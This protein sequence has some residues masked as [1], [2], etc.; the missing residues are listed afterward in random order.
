MASSPQTVI[1]M[2][3]PRANAATAPQTTPNKVVGA[4]ADN[5]VPVMAATAGSG[6]TMADKVMTS[7]A[8]LAQLLPTGT[9]L[10]YQ[11][12]SPSFTR[13]GVDCTASNQWLTAA[14]VG[15]LAGLSLLLSF[16]DSVVGTDGRLY[17]GVATPRGFN[18]FNLSGQEEGLQ[19][20]P[21]QLR[22]LRLRP[23][24]YVHAIFAAVVFLTVAFSDVG[25]QRC[26]FP[27]AGA[28]TSEL[29][30]NLPLGTAFL[31]SFVFLIFPTTRKGI[32]Y[33]DTTPHQKASD[34]D[35]T[36]TPVLLLPTKSQQHTV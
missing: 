7:A 27:H 29:L 12:L 34:D 11:A 35:D 28:N 3:S 10:A 8:N 2:S 16:T 26:F 1:Q 5:R 21:G 14:L 4:D 9:V 24:D 6:G 36:T 20:A 23:L 17:Y 22:R 33:S 31:S 32:G 15:V 25:L 18:V 30:K 13:H 19:W